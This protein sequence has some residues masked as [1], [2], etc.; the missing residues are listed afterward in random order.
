LRICWLLISASFIEVMQQKRRVGEVPPTRPRENLRAAL[1]QHWP[2]LQERV[3]QGQ[4]AN[5]VFGYFEPPSAAA[6]SDRSRRRSVSRVR[7]I[8]GLC[9]FISRSSAAPGAAAPCR[10]RRPFK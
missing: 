5:C 1:R 3:G 9:F 4:E 2:A 8:F 7:V 6:A 10:A